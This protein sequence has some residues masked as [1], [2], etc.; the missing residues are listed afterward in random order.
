MSVLR[1]R[2]VLGLAAL[3]SDRAPVESTIS[4]SFYTVHR[5]QGPLT[6]GILEFVLPTSQ[7]WV[8]LADSFFEVDVT[9]TVDPE[10]ANPA[11]GVLYLP[12][13]HPDCSFGRERGYIAAEAPQ[14]TA[15]DGDTDARPPTLAM[16]EWG[17][18]CLF[19]SVET[20]LN[21]TDV[22]S[23]TGNRTYSTSAKYKLMLGDRSEGRAVWTSADLPQEFYVPEAPAVTV[24]LGTLAVTPGTL[25]AGGTAVTG[26]ADVAG[27][28][29]VNVTAG[30]GVLLTT[31]GA[32]VGAT[33]RITAA[34]SR[35]GC[36]AMTLSE[37]PKA[38]E[39]GVSWISS[40]QFATAFQPNAPNDPP[41]PAYNE[42][43]FMYRGGLLL[44][45]RAQTVPARQWPF[46]ANA[47]LRFMPEDTIWRTKRVLPP[48]VEIRCRLTKEDVSNM[49]QGVA[50][51]WTAA[52]AP[53][54]PKDITA[55]F[56]RCEL[57]LKK[58]VL[59][60]SPAAE[61]QAAIASSRLHYPV[62]RTRREVRTAANGIVANLF[63]GQQRPAMIMVNFMGNITSA[64]PS[65]IRG[66]L[67]KFAAYESNWHPPVAGLPAA[68]LAEPIGSRRLA[69]VHSAQINVGGTNYPSQGPWRAI[70]RN[71]NLKARDDPGANPPAF[72]AAGIYYE[73]PSESYAEYLNALGLL[74]GMSDHIPALT[75]AEW[76][77]K[78]NLFVFLLAQPDAISVLEH[79]L[80]VP[81]PSTSID[82]NFEFDHPLDPTAQCE[83]I[84]FYP[85][86]IE[87][88]GVNR[89]VRKSWS[90]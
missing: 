60:D 2:D 77:A 85:G 56:T 66:K 47:T 36:T 75:R 21:G 11:G 90:N 61:M 9:F 59:Y 33:E 41:Q 4:Q 84:A 7:H 42:P 68:D 22:S 16:P 27:D 28:L 6:D 64:T 14:A 26:A 89:E 74:H 44:R 34:L 10:R 78:P 23:Q 65:D 30:R 63:S 46:Q 73:K 88:S 67:N 43:S 20:N 71:T 38:A 76:N 86:T 19:S 45:S 87:I 55:A 83:A 49:L 50:R 1:T 54:T 69:R 40:P 80:A 82:L 48:G 58:V 79:D 5:P 12:S 29:A 51:S 24:G 72:D 3:A 8:A 13:D 70:Q 57:F 32:P 37:T 81:A 53:I 39:T 15:T 25:V 62:M 31:R 35:V 52:N 17:V 18:H